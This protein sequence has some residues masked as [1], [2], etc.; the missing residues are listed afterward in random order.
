LKSSIQQK[1]RRKKRRR[2]KKTPPTPKSRFKSNGAPSYEV[3]HGLY[4]VLIRCY[5]LVSRIVTIFDFDCSRYEALFIPLR[6]V[7]HH[8]S[9]YNL[10][11]T[12]NAMEHWRIAHALKLKIDTVSSAYKNQTEHAL[13]N[14]VLRNPTLGLWGNLPDPCDPSSNTNDTGLWIEIPKKY[15]EHF[16]WSIIFIFTLA[17]LHSSA[18]YYPDTKS[19]DEI[20]GDFR[21]V[22][23]KCNERVVTAL[24]QMSIAHTNNV[25][26]F[27][28]LQ[29]FA[30]KMI[31]KPASSVVP[32][33]RSFMVSWELIQRQLQLGTETGKALRIHLSRLGCAN[34]PQ[35]RMH[36]PAAGQK[37][38]KQNE[39]RRLEEEI[40][41]RKRKATNA[42]EGGGKRGGRKK[43]QS[44]K[45]KGND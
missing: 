20:E 35:R 17:D 23:F 44:R 37:D 10:L 27:W 7:T 38:L 40:E 32:G 12:M 6:N 15:V 24:R 19:W 36:L 13:G 18:Y 34:A 11:N 21:T 14:L 1:K 9:N 28:I 2:K 26:A 41:N 45:A 42:A 5:R 39:A 3:F 43:R 31:N 4:A 33:V 25:A 8:K 16:S 22:R 30:S 29:A